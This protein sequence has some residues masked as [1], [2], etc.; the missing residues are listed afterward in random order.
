MK[1]F[2]SASSEQSFFVECVREVANER[3]DDV[4]FCPEK[5]RDLRDKTLLDKVFRELNTSHLVL[6]DLTM[7][8]CTDE[9]Y[10]NSGVLV[11]YGLLIAMKSLEYIFMFCEESTDRDRLPPLIPRTEVTPYSTDDRE[12]FKEMIR[13]AIEQFEREAPE[14]ERRIMRMADASQILVH[15][16]MRDTVR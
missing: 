3:H 15:F 5:F 11:E 4:V 10:A 6:M 16:F 12:V 7:N 9:F 1:I 2:I 13:K 14:R 8:Q